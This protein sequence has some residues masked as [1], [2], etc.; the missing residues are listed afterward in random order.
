MYW[1]DVALWVLSVTL[2]N[3]LG[4]V[5]AIEKTIK[6]SIPIVNCSKCASFWT[7]LVY[8]FIVGKSFIVTLAVSFC[9]SYVALWVELLCGCIDTLYNKCYESIY[10]E[11]T[12]TTTDTKT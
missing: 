10:S 2:A 6:H 1:C 9:C 11:K 7:V 4:L 3:H 5:E 12:D 8:S